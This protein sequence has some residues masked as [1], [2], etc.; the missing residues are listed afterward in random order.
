MRIALARRKVLTMCYP[1]TDYGEEA[2]DAGMSLSEFLARGPSLKDVYSSIGDRR[3]AAH[4]S[5]RSIS[6][7]RRAPTSNRSVKDQER[8]A[9]PTMARNTKVA[10]AVLHNGSPSTLARLPSGNANDY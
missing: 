10:K 9:E 5:R 4:E 8:E 1:L 7:H 2:K 6:V 3:Q